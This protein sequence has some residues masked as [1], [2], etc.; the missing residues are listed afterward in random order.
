[1]LLKVATTKA[2]EW[3]TVKGGANP[4]P[5]FETSAMDDI[6]VESAFDAIA[7]AALRRGEKDD[8]L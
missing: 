4:I 6:N 7:R 1:M 5:L 3:C 2:Q 8:D